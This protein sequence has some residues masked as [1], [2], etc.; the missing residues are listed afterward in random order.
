MEILG[1]NNNSTVE[2]IR[3]KQSEKDFYE[4]IAK[5]LDGKAISKLT[6]FAKTYFDMMYIKDKKV[7]LIKFIDTKQD[8]YDILGEEIIEILEEEEAQS[9]KIFEKH[10]S[11]I[12]I[13]RIVIMPY[14]KAYSKKI[15]MIGK[16]RYDELKMEPLEFLK[17]L[18][19]ENDE[20]HLELLRYHLTPELHVL[21]KRDDLSTG[22]NIFKKIV[23]TSEE[24]QISAIFVD[25]EQVDIINTIKYGKTLIK[26]FS[27]SGKTTLMFAQAIKMAR[28]Y[29]K[30]KFLYITFD[31]QLVHNLKEGITL[32]QI[33]LPNLKIISY[34]QYVVLLGKKFGLRI[35]VEQKSN[36]NKEFEKI[37]KKVNKIYENDHV[38]KG[39]F[40]DEG[41]N[42]RSQD[43]EFLQ[44]NLYKSKWV[45]QVAIDMGK[46]LK[47]KEKISE[48]EIENIGFD[49]IIELKK[50]YRLT[51]E[52]LIYLE[53]LKN[54]MKSYNKDIKFVGALGRSLEGE[55]Y[56]RGQVIFKSSVDTVGMI[57]DI[58]QEI[59]KLLEEGNSY[60]D[61]AIVYPFNKRSVKK[62]GQIYSQY[63]VKNGLMKAGLPYIFASGQMSGLREKVGIT[64]SNIYN[65]CNLEYKVII[66]CEID[67]LIEVIQE[68]IGE[69]D[70]DNYLMLYNIIYTA[71][72]R[73]T[74]KV[75]LYLR[76]D[77]RN[78][79]LS[80]LLVENNI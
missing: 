38:F 68:K 7:M 14:A 50:N 20:I 66:L 54:K 4:N 65:V 5:Y 27:G 36:F 61:I 23:F 75:Y 60:S 17:Y 74:D 10:F 76:G 15:A 41:E 80:N 49:N 47:N 11:N 39:I 42:Y 79:N 72:S 29:P 53:N 3:L 31:K 43:L 35:N 71:T 56:K 37:L 16:D 12:N 77:T 18:G 70:I 40:V 45:F 30:D 24:K 59:N 1:R 21:K 19:E 73:S 32:R 2:T 25:K 63:I 26:G 64:L 48:E 58:C 6:P 52:Q 51:G 57:S 55:S 28:L 22:E 13:S 44:G 69:G 46:D 78:K 9:R 8:T 67:S 33:K 34:H 62:K